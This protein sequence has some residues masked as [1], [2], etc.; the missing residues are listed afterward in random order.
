MPP[1]LDNR[2]FAQPRPVVFA[3][4]SALYAGSG[5]Q[6]D[7]RLPG[8]ILHESEVLRYSTTV[9]EKVCQGSFSAQ[10]AFI[11]LL[12]TEFGV[13]INDPIEYARIAPGEGAVYCSGDYKGCYTAGIVYSETSV[14]FHE[15][16]HAVA[17]VGSIGGTRP[18][19]EGLAETFS[20]GLNAGVP[21]TDLATILKDFPDDGS[22][23]YKMAL[24]VR[25]LI[26]EYGIEP[27]LDFMRRSRLNDP[28]D[29]WTMQF[30]ESIGVALEDAMEAF[31]AYPACSRWQNRDAL[32]EC[33]TTPTPW[34]GDKWSIQ[35][36][37]D[38]SSDDVLGPHRTSNLNVIWTERALDVAQ[39][40]EYL[41]TPTGTGE[42]WGMIII[43]RCG[44][45]WDAVEV[46]LKPSDE[47]RSITLPA[48]RYHVLVARDL[49]DPRPAGVELMRSS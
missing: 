6:P 46:N 37:L 21:D 9:D 29:T 36:D 13:E 3:L 8:T 25:F 20:N 16:T 10:E 2:K 35:T 40:G 1:A 18:F 49:S 22:G 12:A 48:G 39:T 43:T 47:P 28:Y 4:I 19:R 26:E 11:R 17:D 23:Y 41:I 33:S 42:A 7:P 44:S 15:L 30:A 34:S 31:E 45:C 27:L 5:C 24:F 38:C 32:V 14:S